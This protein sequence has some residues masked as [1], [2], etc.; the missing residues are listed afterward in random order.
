[1]KSVTIGCSLSESGWS[2]LAS[3]SLS[4]SGWSLI[5]SGEIL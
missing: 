3:E 4:V 2:L 5:A 1:M